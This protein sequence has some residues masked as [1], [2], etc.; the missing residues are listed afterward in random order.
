MEPHDNGRVLAA[1]LIGT[2]VVMIGGVGLAI[3]SRSVLPADDSGALI[4]ALVVALGFG[5]SWLAM[6]YVTA[7]VSGGH[8]NPAV[9]LGMLLAK[10]V[11]LTHAVFA[12][13]G[14]ILGGVGGAAIVYG[15]ASGQ[16]GFSRGQ[17]AANLWTSK[18]GKSYGLGSTIV[19]EVIL[20]A[21]L[22]MVLLF[23]HNRRS[24]AAIGAV[25]SGLLVVVLYLIAQPI[26]G[27]GLNPARSIGAAVF[28]DTT[29]DALEQLWAFVLF[30]LIGAV[31]GVVL[32]LVIDDARLEDTMLAAVP[33]AT[34]MRD[35]A[36]KIADEAVDVVEDA[37]N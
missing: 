21:I 11:T 36:D 24:T 19:A 29:F 25:V 2:A 6:W 3:L 30:P 10:E 17:F 35:A 33:G 9:T 28:A 18:G 26:D 1:E 20:T 31:V 16:P 13:I 27:G 15:L 4:R 8:L 34:A 12:W 7:P 23:L 37:T 32:W 14:Q 5:L 22:V